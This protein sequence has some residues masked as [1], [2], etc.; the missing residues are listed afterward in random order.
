MLSYRRGTPCSIVGINGAYHRDTSCP[1][2]GINAVLSSQP[3]CS[4]G[5]PRPVLSSRHILFY[6]RNRSCLIV[7]TQPL[8]ASGNPMTSRTG[9]TEPTH[10]G[11]GARHDHLTRDDRGRMT[12]HR[13]QK[14]NRNRTE[15]EQHQNR[16]RTAKT[17]I[18]G[19]RDE[20]CTHEDRVSSLDP[21]AP[22][23]S[24]WAGSDALFVVMQQNSKRA[25][26]LGTK[27]CKSGSTSIHNFSARG[28]R[29]YVRFPRRSSESMER[30]NEISSRIQAGIWRL[31]A[32]QG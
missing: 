12:E 25:S 27:E 30:E 21:F 7:G 2:G 29:K 28:V 17:S 31:R 24:E 26:S 23:Q 9:R 8:R 10:F 18:A 19:G 13:K 15:I 3:S 4:I 16:T 20:V 32:A 11:D 1:I 22:E 5:M 6:H 14:S